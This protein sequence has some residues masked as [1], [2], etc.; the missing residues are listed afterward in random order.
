MCF[1]NEN[2]KEFLL[3]SILVIFLQIL[4][5][6]L[7]WKSAVNFSSVLLDF[8]SEIYL[9]FLCFFFWKIVTKIFLEFLKKFRSE[10]LR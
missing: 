2:L 4:I 5:F 10:T 8:L 1:F 6:F 3:N 7:S 9:N